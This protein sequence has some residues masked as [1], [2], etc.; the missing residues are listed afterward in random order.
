VPE[1]AAPVVQ[2]DVAAPSVTVTPPA[3]QVD[4]AAPAVTVQAEVPPAQVVVAH[5]TKAVQTVER[6]PETLEITRTV[7]TY[8]TGQAKE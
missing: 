2:V 1:A 3:V 8:E 7:T 4:V 6:D 5:P